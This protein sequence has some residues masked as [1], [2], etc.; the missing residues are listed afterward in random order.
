MNW[1]EILL[2]H[3]LIDSSSLSP[4]RLRVMNRIISS[5]GSLLIQH[6]LSQPTSFFRIKLWILIT[7]SASIAFLL[8]LIVSIFL[9]FIFHRRKC[10]P[11]PF[12][13]RSKLCLPLSH[14]PL[15]N[16][17]YYPYNRCG[18]D[19]ESQRISQVDW[20]SAHLPYYTRSF[21]STGSFGSFTM[22]TF[23]EIK[24][25]TDGF[26]D[27]NLIAKGDSSMVYRGTFLGTVTVAVKRFSPIHQRFFT[28]FFLFDLLIVIL[29]SY[30]FDLRK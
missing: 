8:V 18:D 12:R 25:V 27:Y 17:P 26:A 9:C 20:F 5:Q 13:L 28:F 15:N 6:K 24:N 22:F 7:A 23:M 4:Q 21:S 3:I 11:E 14:I 1:V 29:E 30:Y 10:R 19:V 16:K 2:F